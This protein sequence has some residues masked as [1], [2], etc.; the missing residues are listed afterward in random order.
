MSS[1]KENGS[2]T[3]LTAHVISPYLISCTYN[4]AVSVILWGIYIS[5][6]HMTKVENTMMEKS[7]TVP[8]MAKSLSLMLTIKDNPLKET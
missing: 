1:E 4:L 5:C 2:R 8:V 3:Q 7:H 6:S